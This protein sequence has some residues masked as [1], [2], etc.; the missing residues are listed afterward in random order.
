[1]KPRRLSE[2]MWD[3][4][5]TYIYANSQLYIAESIEGVGTI[6]TN[7]ESGCVVPID[8][9]CG[10]YQVPHRIISE[11]FCDMRQNVRRALA[12]KYGMRII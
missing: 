3:N 6:T 7:L 1:M 2:V 4:D 8:E 9:Q 12:K 5:R 10:V 11:S